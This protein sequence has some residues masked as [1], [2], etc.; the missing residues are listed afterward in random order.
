MHY[1][2][3]IRRMLGM[4]GENESAAPDNVKLTPDE[5]AEYD[6][7]YPSGYIYPFSFVHPVTGK[8]TSE[9]E[10]NAKLRMRQS[11]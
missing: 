7:G 11:G 3:N 9:G 6:Y 2:Y 4:A 8:T 5:W 10:R 1:A